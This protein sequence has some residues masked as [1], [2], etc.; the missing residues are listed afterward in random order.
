MGNQAFADYVDANVKL[1]HINNKY[2]SKKNE[3]MH[4][5]LALLNRS[6]VVPILPGIKI[7]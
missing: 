3:W 5:M 2:V 6:D 1:T 7:K 4:L